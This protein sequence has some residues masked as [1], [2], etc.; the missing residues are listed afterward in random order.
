[1]TMHPDGW[2]GVLFDL[3]GT[4]A[5]TVDLILQSFRHTM[6]EH[7]DEVPPDELFLRGHRFL[8]CIAAD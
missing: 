6:S 5:D 2:S 4:L 7:L 1:M 8:Y 3:D